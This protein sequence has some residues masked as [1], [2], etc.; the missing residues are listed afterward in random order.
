M[1]NKG[2]GGCFS[3]DGVRHL[4][5]QYS[6][7]ELA[8]LVQSDKTSMRNIQNYAWI[9]EGIMPSPTGGFRVGTGTL[10]ASVPYLGAV[11][12]ILMNSIVYI[13][14]ASQ[15][16][17][18]RWLL[19]EIF[20]PLLWAALGSFQI[21]GGGAAMAGRIS[22]SRRA[23]KKVKEYLKL[24]AILSMDTR[25]PDDDLWKSKSLNSIIP[26]LSDQTTKYTWKYS[27]EFRKELFGQDLRFLYQSEIRN[28]VR[29]GIE[30]VV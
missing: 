29:K 11:L 9:M 21:P 15:I 27:E 13:R 1:T 3:S 12:I 30:D 8:K 24:R 16:S 25:D 4:D 23:A 26:G 17:A 7:K 6:R 22:P 28:R 2:I 20:W 10:F 19:C 5:Y 14:V 18:P